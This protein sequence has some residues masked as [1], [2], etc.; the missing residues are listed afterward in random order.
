MGKSKR[1]G[2][3]KVSKIGKAISAA[4]TV[5]SVA[6]A[7]EESL[8]KVINYLA[9]QIPQAI[10][11]QKQLVAVPDLCVDGYLLTTSQAEEQLKSKG[12]GVIFVE[13][14]LADADTKYREYC[15][16]QV[17]GTNPK[18][19][20]KVEPGSIVAVKYISQK[21]IDRSV[22]LYEEAEA[23]KIDITNRKKARK[24]KRNKKVGQVIQSVKDAP[25]MIPRPFT[26][27]FV[28]VK[29]KSEDN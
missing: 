21:V 6:D 24:R 5:L 27:K 13:A 1:K 28:L 16:G 15:E 3:G 26:K 4:K 22:Q 2:A 20:A 17:I 19:N 10:E 12:L 25:Q 29:P 9:D 18:A 8:P 23:H 14:T 11:K 7:A